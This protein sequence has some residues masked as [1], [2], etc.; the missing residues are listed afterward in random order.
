MPSMQ[1]FLN[2]QIYAEFFTQYVY[3]NGR[4]YK[5]YNNFYVNDI[6]TSILVAE[7][8]NG[9]NKLCLN[10]ISITKNNEEFL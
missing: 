7:N 4:Y 5:M 10:F 8:S 1:R 6:F 9:S 3:N 2:R